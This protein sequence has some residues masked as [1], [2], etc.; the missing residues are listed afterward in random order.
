MNQFFK[1]LIV[2]ALVG[3]GVVGCANSQGGE[4]EHCYGNGTCNAGLVCS[5][6]VCVEAP[7][8]DAG[9]TTQD[10]G[11]A[12]A[13]AGAGDSGT[14]DA[15][16]V[17]PAPPPVLGPQLDR[18]GRPMMTNVFLDPF[19]AQRNQKRDTWNGQSDPN[20]WSSNAP[21]LINML[22]ILDGLD[23]VC[24]NAFLRGGEF[25][26]VAPSLVLASDT[27]VLDTSFGTCAAPFAIERSIANDCGGRVPGADVVDQY[28]S[29]FIAGTPSG[30]TDG[31]SASP[32]LSTTF[33]YLGAP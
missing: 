31:A 15:G 4:R 8:R 21:E 28:Y 13:D 33:P 7:Q 29:L 12:T 6:N 25:R 19:S 20:A 14:V 10:A 1:S 30:Y 27:L 22:G 17:T 11:Q 32:D 24:G 18:V 9:A 26:Y 2:L 23:G 16:E 3:V 5:S